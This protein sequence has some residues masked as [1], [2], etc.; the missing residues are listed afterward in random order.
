LVW[1]SHAST[2]VSEIDERLLKFAFFVSLL[3]PTSDEK[4]RM[5]FLSPNSVRV[6]SI[7]FMAR[8]SS[9]SDFWS[10]QVYNAGESA[11]IFLPKK[12]GTTHV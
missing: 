9:V 7:I 11:L 12:P 2:L 4:R 8:L 1:I 10:N 3:K 6:C 5:M